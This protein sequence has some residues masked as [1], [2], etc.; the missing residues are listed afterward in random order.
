[1]MTKTKAMLT[2]AV[3]VAALLGTLTGAKS[4]CGTQE[5]NE[6]WNSPVQ[7]VMTLLEAADGTVT[8]ELVLISTN[9]ADHQF[10]DTAQAP[11]VRAPD[12]S[13]VSL[14]LGDP[15]H[16]TASSATD[17]NLT[18]E[19]GETYQFRFE[20]DDPDAADQVAGGNFVAV[21]TAPDD[22]V[23][24]EISK[25][26]AFAGDTAQLSW[27]PTERYALV[28]ITYEPTGELVYANFDFQEPTFDG[29]KWARLK[30]GGTFDLGVDVFAE[31]GEYTI[32]FCAVDKVSDFSQELSAE[33]GVLSGFLIGRCAES[34]TLQVTD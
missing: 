21:M 24:F 14:T 5:S 8:A 9:T 11:R 19:P 17:A 25:E 28:N 2:K 23:T 26:P 33:L 6:T 27:T 13:E 10:V 3:L 30:R 15:G 1:M 12:G 34:T 16:Y 20:L 29:S 7:A 22:V 31:A 32:E 4:G 18:Y